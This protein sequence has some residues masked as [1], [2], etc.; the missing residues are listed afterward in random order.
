[1]WA[2][3]LVFLATSVEISRAQAGA[4][5]QNSNE[6]RIAELQNTV[7]ISPAGTTLW[8]LAQTN[9]ILHPF[10]RLRTGEHGRV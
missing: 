1:M 10:D 2:A 7:E 6:I 9:Q 3:I 5:N 8:M 4:G